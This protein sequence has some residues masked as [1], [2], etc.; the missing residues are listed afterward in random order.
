MLKHSLRVTLTGGV[1]ATSLLC[2]AHYTRFSRIATYKTWTN[3]CKSL[4][5]QA[6]AANPAVRQ[7]GQLLFYKEDK[8]VSLIFRFK[9]TLKGGNQAA[10]RAPFHFVVLWHSGAIYLQSVLFSLRTQSFEGPALM[11]L[12]WWGSGTTR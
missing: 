11:M 6:S 5:A 3:H 2:G 10:V 7:G 9:S 1:A 12:G 4:I 8:L